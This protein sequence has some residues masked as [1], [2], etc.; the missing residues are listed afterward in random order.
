MARDARRRDVACEGELRCKAVR[1]L[2]AHLALLVLATLVLATRARAEAPPDDD[3]AAAVTLYERADQEDTALRFADALR[4]YEAALGRSSSFRYAPRARV[5]ADMLRSHDEGDF[6][7]LTRLETVRRDPHLSSDPAALAGLAHDAEAFP[8]GRVKVEAR[9]LVAEAYLHRLDRPDDAL[10]L[11]R[12]VLADPAADA[13]TARQASREIVTT[14]LDRGA[15]DEAAEVAAL[16]RTDP[17]LR[18]EVT[19]RLRRRALHRGG[20]LVLVLFL[21]AVVAGTVR[22]RSLARQRLGKLAS[23]GKVALVF[24]AWIALAGGALASS[25]ESGNA[26]PFLALGAAV[27]PL[28]L[29]ARVWSVVAG[30]S[31]AA[32]AGRA[33]LSAAAVLA[34]A[35]LVLEAVDVSYLQDFGL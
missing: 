29:A 25:Y 7:P 6:A 19:V 3:P 1:A 22:H 35:L 15:L 10:A 30:P 26:T 28:L 4:D 20:V 33:A 24:S 14:L 32:A 16:P 12:L 9:H 2:R 5:R 23:F 13:L 11:L 31:R 17:D 34:T 27:L 18:H 21:G 8:P